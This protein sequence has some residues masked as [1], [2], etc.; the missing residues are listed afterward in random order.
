MTIERIQPDGL[1]K[2]TAYTHV[3]KHGNVVYLAGQTAADSSG[4]IVGVGD[5]EAQADRV[6]E[7]IK[8]GLAAAGSDATKILRMVTYLT[9]RED[10]EGY[11]ASR[12]RHLPTDLPA[13]T[14]LFISG[15]ASPDY[16]IEVDVTAALD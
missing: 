11:R 10:I 4:N 12:I 5:I 3:V 8:I 1:N 7:N 6:Y 13:S 9:R 2:P 15:L 14:L 16:L